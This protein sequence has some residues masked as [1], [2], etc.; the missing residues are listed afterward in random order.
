MKRVSGIVLL[1]LVSCAAPAAARTRSGPIFLRGIAVHVERAQFT[2]TTH[3]RGTFVVRL[4]AQTDVSEKGI[5]GPVTVLDKD[6]VGVRGIEKGRVLTAI[7]V[8]IYPVR[9]KAF[10]V[11]GTVA[12]N[13]GATLTVAYGGHHLRVIILKATT[14]NVGN[15]TSLLSRPCG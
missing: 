3:T 8:R 2:L 1:L 9:P 13:D 10:S 14:S 7:W 5:H 12:G 15:G 4:R 6:H 11:K